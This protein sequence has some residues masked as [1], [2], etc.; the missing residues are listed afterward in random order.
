VLPTDTQPV[1]RIASELDDA[2]L[3]A[4]RGHDEVVLVFGPGAVAR[5]VTA[6]LE[7]LAQGAPGTRCTSIVLSA[8]EE[9]AD[10]Q[11]V[12]DADRIFYLSC[13][14]LPEGELA[15]LIDGARGTNVRE[16]SADVFLS[17]E[18]LRRMAMA[19]NVADVADAVE[20][21][22]GSVVETRRSRC[23]L[24]DRERQALWCPGDAYEEASA[25]VGL[26]SFIVRT[27]MTVCLTRLD[28]DP[29]A[30]L[31]VDNPDGNP[32][33]R[34]LG[35]PVRAPRG[36]I[37]AVLIA[38]RPEGEDA[39]EAAEVARLEALAAHAS[40]YLATW[41]IETPGSP[42]RHNA[43]RELDQ[44]LL[45]GPEPLRLDGG[46]TRGTSWIAA[47]AFAAIVVA[48]VFVLGLGHG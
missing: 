35:V 21:A 31:E 48:L 19:E 33:D 23:V 25:A 41:L 24:F 17:P 18:D 27:G 46:W 13:G 12:I 20:R 38:L 37:V 4:I 14:E 8:Q 44:P 6:A 1:Y 39:F 34:F 42:F 2:Q 30:D 9:M 7:L 16:G 36:A 5:D 40:P 28:G 22:I 45:S 15:A 47:A 26:A 3:G 43:L 32:S 29:R 10:F 11:P